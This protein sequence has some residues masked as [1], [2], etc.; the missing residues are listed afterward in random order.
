MCGKLGLGK[1]CVTF[2]TATVSRRYKLAQ[3]AGAICYV[4]VLIWNWVGND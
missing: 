4:I 2:I 3:A 1:V